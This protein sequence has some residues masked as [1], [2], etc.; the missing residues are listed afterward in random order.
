MTVFI[1][2]IK[3]SFLPPHRKQ[4]LFPVYLLEQTQPIYYSQAVTKNK[5]TNKFV[6]H[7]GNTTPVSPAPLNHTNG[8]FLLLWQ[9]FV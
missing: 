4:H 2:A 5:R 3:F 7:L 6:Y 1:A 8:C 9:T